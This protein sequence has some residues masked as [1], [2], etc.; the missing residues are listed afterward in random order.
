MSAQ[1]R[2]AMAPTPWCSTSTRTVSSSR[3]SLVIFFSRF[4]NRLAALLVTTCPRTYQL[5]AFAKLRTLAFFPVIRKAS[6]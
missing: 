3:E 5:H 6:Q 2:Q 1:Q 4:T